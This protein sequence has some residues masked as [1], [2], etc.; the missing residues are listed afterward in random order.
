MWLQGSA[1][2]R[3][4]RPPNILQGKPLQDTGQ[5]DLGFHLGKGSANA[6]ARAAAKRYV[7]EGR[8]PFAATLKAFRPEGLRLLP[9]ALVAVGGDEAITRVPARSS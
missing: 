5:D 4:H 2:V 3:P 7:G 6:G 8:G 1:H 9:V